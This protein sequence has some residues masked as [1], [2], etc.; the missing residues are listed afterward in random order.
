DKIVDPDPTTRD[1]LAA[2][3]THYALAG[4]PVYVIVNN[5]A[6]GSSPLSCRALAERI[7]ELSQAPSAADAQ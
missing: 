1:V 6:E 4:H 5:K 3:A 2:L 7:T